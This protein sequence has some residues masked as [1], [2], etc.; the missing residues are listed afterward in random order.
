MQNISIYD[1]EKEKTICTIL[2]DKFKQFK[3]DFNNKKFV[4]ID[5][6]CI[7]IKNNED[8]GSTEKCVWLDKNPKKFEDVKFSRDF[9]VLLAR[10]N[11]NNSVAYDLKTCYVIKKL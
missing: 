5:D 2:T 11:R 7:S 9:K 8:E 4:L 6:I 10:M 3:I 1:T